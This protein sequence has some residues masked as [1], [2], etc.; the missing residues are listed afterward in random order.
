VRGIALAIVGVFEPP[1]VVASNAPIEDMTAALEISD[2]VAAVNGL[3]PSLRSWATVIVV[4][5]NLRPGTIRALAAQCP[6]V[7]LVISTEDHLPTWIDRSPMHLDEHPAPPRDATGFLG[8]TLVTYTTPSRYGL[9]SMHLRIDAAGRIAE[10]KS[11]SIYLFETIPDDRHIRAMLDAFYDRVG[12]DSMAQG[13]VPAL[14][15]QDV[16]TLGERYSGAASC[17]KCHQRE[18]DQ[19]KTTTHAT[20]FKTLLDRHRNFQPRCVQCHVVGFGTPYGYKLG[21]PS[22]NL[23]N[24]QCEDCHGPAGRHVVAPSAENIHRQ[25]PEGRCMTCHTL[26][27]SDR[28]VYS[29]RVVFVNHGADARSQVA[30]RTEAQPHAVKGMKPGR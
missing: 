11:N 15:A 26:E 23:A 20:A 10:A 18:Y 12:R 4:I 3:I 29:E 13:S 19:W 1:P 25:V 24:V 6:E 30:R 28:F 7:D 5:G 22:E 8:K 27:H 17:M 14:F 21:D 2:P 9:V 16:Q